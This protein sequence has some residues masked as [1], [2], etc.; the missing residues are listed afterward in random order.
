MKN[1]HLTPSTPSAF[2]GAA[3]VRASGTR[4][5]R[6]LPCMAHRGASLPIGRGIPR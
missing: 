1:A 5:N 6:R 4:R 3:G 2:A